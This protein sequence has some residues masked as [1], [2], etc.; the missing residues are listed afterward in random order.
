MRTSG[1]YPAS[2]AGF[3]AEMERP[4]TE[5]LVQ[6]GLSLL[7][8]AGIGT[9]YDFL[10]A[11]RRSGASRCLAALCD[12]LFCA[13]LCFALFAF[14]LGP[15]G[16]SLRLFMLA[17]AGGGWALYGLT[18]SP[19]VLELFGF[20]VK[21]LRLICLPLR[22]SLSKLRKNKKIQK[23][24]FPKFI[25]RFTMM[26]NR[27]GQS[28]RGGRSPEGVGRV[29]ERKGRYSYSAD[30]GG[31]FAVRAG[32]PGLDEGGSSKVRSLQGRTPRRGRRA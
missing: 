31:A 32:E 1:P 16:G 2:G 22:R 6:A 8:G 27:R 19:Y 5:Q 28:R 11:M 9:A 14:G 7:L 4:L 30:S 29:E 23:N 24:L 3:S 17:C 21:K 15:G 13:G 20:V 10:R 12:L 26:K 18:L 25:A